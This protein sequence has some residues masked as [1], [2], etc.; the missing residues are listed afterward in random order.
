MKLK[1]LVALVTAG[2]LCLGMSLTAFAADGS[3]EEVPTMGN[4]KGDNGLTAVS[5]SLTDKQKED[6]VNSAEDY[7]KK[8]YPE[9]ADKAEIIAVGDYTLYDAEKG[10]YIFSGKV[11]GGSATFDFAVPASVDTKGFKEGAAAYALH[12]VEGKG[13][14]PVSGTLEKDAYGNWVI[15]VETD[16]FS[17]FVFFK[18]M[19]NGDI[20]EVNWKT[21]KIVSSTST[22]TRKASPKTGE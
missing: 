1:K 20:V 9:I 12:F 15:R 18:V 16:S 2:A 4:G 8:N 14:T 22:T 17:P 3:R 6:L 5:G 13:W 21:G 10:E 11:P 19:S 7:L